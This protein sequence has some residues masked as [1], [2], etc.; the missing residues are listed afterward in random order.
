MVDRPDNINVYILYAEEDAELKQELESHLSLLQRHGY[1]DVWHEGLIL[2]GQAKDKV[3]SEYMRKAHIILLLVSANFL[4]PECYNKYEAELRIAYQ[5]QKEG[6]VK[7]IPVILRHCVWQL[8]LLA[9]LNPLPQG[10]H[11]VRSRHWESE[12]VAFANIAS[13]LRNIADEIIGA[14]KPP[15]TP[16]PL[17]K[18]ATP[19]PLKK[20]NI[21]AEE[22]ALRLVNDLFD[23]MYRFEAG[24]G[25]QMAIS[26][27]HRSLVVNGSLEEHFLRDKFWKAYEKL[28]RYVYPAQFV[29]GKAS[30]RQNVGAGHQKE[31]GE[32][33]I[34]NLRKKEDLGGL[35]GQVRVF[36]PKDGGLPKITSLSL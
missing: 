26:I 5:R 3:I 4:A 7:I 14:P 15:T 36:F 29:S 34:Y 1:I 25:A 12:D 28:P 13:G 30:G 21:S 32:E 9:G 33:W 11:P 16:P 8:D 2:P 23:L 22:A 6:E 20:K 19:P 31:W 27:V 24:M 17:P 18:K 10:G 35:P